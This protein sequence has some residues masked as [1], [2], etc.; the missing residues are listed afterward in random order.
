MLLLLAIACSDYQV[1][2]GP[3]VPPA[4]PPGSDPDAALGSP[5]D[6]TD[7]G[8]GYLAQYF[9]LSVDHSDVEPEPDVVPPSGPDA[10]DWFDGPPDDSTYLPSLDLGADWWPLDQGL[11]GDPAY[12]AARFTAWIRVWDS[13]TV[14]L[15]VGAADDLWL[16]VNDEV[17]YGDAGVHAFSPSSV[18]IELG[19]GQYP[20]EVR[21]AHRAGA[22][23]GLRF[24]VASGDV[25]LCY[26][27]FTEADVEQE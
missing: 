4:E 26:P 16:L 9:N 12:F 5:P 17:V 19:S 27:D 8:G 25:T 21:Y 11:A 18:Q 24:R 23:N 7:C 14:T 1:Y 15:S 13:G 20:L 22:D 10:V 3:P 2:S 6:W